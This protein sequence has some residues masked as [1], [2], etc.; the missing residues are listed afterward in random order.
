MAKLNR[1]SADTVQRQLRSTGD[2]H[3]EM[4]K[5]AQEFFKKKSTLY[6]ICDETFS[7]HPYSKLIEGTDDHFDSKIYHEIRSHKILAFEISDGKHILPL[8]SE[9]LFGK[10]LSRKQIP[11]RFEIVQKKIFMIKILF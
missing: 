1:V 2:S 11:S 8:F 5:I 3:Q 6:L 4:L 9:F 7:H 10:M